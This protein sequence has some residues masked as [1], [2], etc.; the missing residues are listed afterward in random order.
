LLYSF[1]ATD[2]AYPIYS[3]LAQSANLY[4]T[5]LFGGNGGWGVVFQLSQGTDGGWGENVMHAFPAFA[6]DGMYPTSGLVADSHG[7][8]Y[9]M[10]SFG[11][12]GGNAG[13]ATPYGCG[14]IFMI[15]TNSET[16]KILHN[17]GDTKED[18]YFPQGY[19]T[20][21][22]KGALYGTTG[23]GGSATTAC[24]SFTGPG[25]EGCGTVFK[26]TP[27]K[28]KGK[29]H[30]AY[31]VLYGFNGADGGEPSAGG[32]TFD[33]AGALYGTTEFGGSGNACGSTG[34]GTVF[35]LVLVGTATTLT[36]LHSFNA[37]D[38]ENPNGVIFGA[39][40]AGPL[41]G[42]TSEGGNGM[43]TVFALTQGRMGG[44]PSDAPCLYG[45]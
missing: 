10:T 17:F 5:T 18:G 37:A 29:P 22:P 11:G 24:A 35:K 40:G 36:V 15:R 44:G 25:T 43:D 45:R 28:I 21:H 33:T 1:D 26:L 20:I 2:G 41:Y 32:L 30:W 4:G 39:N 34:C 3:V 23:A 14:T 9:G 7:N 42:T 27:Q 16:Y 8:L 19:L 6:A 12:S 13:C 31:S 38:G